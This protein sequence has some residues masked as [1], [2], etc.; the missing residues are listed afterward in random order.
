MTRLLTCGIATEKCSI[1]V[2]GFDSEMGQLPIGWIVP[3]LNL[4]FSFQFIIFNL[5]F[6]FT[7]FDFNFEFMFNL[8][9][10]IAFL[11]PFFIHWQWHP[12]AQISCPIVFISS[13]KCCLWIGQSLWIPVTQFSCPIVFI[14]STKCPVFELDSPCESQLLSFP[15]P[16]SYLWILISVFKSMGQNK[17]QYWGGTIHLWLPV[18]PQF[19]K[20]FIYHKRPQ[21]CLTFVIFHY[22]H[23]T[24]SFDNQFFR[25]YT[26]WNT[27][28]TE[29]PNFHTLNW[30]FKQFIDFSAIIQWKYL[31]FTPL[32]DF[33]S[34]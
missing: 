11:I 29:I 32:T 1:L 3:S 9:F 27:Y 22:L 10:H 34:N 24:Y 19:L 7:V 31:I 18:K 20:A 6:E 21:N 28:P 23:W 16:L 30:F 26:P 12:V 33:L 2:W 15:V 13:T 5:S 25:N 8:S 14:S 4:N 17:F